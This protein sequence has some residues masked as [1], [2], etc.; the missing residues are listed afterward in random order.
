MSGFLCL[1]HFFPS[2][3][4]HALPVFLKLHSVHTE[5]FVPY[6]RTDPQLYSP[7]IRVWFLW[8]EREEVYIIHNL[9]T[10]MVS[11]HLEHFGS[12]LRPLCHV[13]CSKGCHIGHCIINTRLVSNQAKETRPFI[14]SVLK[15]SFA[16]SRLTNFQVEAKFCLESMAHLVAQGCCFY[17]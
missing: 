11:F 13:G 10:S 9:E 2:S 4:T 14:L 15:E 8:G 17:I 1:V 16:P 6:L 5:P 3:P 7:L 12:F